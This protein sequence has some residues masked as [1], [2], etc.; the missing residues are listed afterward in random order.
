MKEQ[1]LSATASPPAAPTAPPAP[2]NLTRTERCFYELL[3]D[4]KPHS[5]PELTQHLWDQLNVNLRVVIKVWIARLRA[6]LPPDIHVI[7]VTVDGFLHYQL[8]RNL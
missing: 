2:A 4:G 7:P 8:V 3:S 6:K 5:I 1:D